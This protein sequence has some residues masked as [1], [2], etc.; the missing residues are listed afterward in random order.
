MVQ[1]GQDNTQ[2]IAPGF[3]DIARAVAG[4]LERLGQLGLTDEERDDAEVSGREVLEEV[5][6]PEPDEG[7][8]RRR[9]RAGVR[10]AEVTSRVR[11]PVAPPGRRWL[12][13]HGEP[14]HH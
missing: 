7:V 8:V 10:P 11:A 2:Q 4:T 6:R 3:E 12:Q 13:L 5:V 1:G 9:L 14:R